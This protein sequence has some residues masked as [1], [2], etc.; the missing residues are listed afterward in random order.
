MPAQA[1]DRQARRVTS[2]SEE[3]ASLTRR[4]TV[5][6]LPALAVAAV[7]ALH[8]NVASTAHD[9]VPQ[10]EVDA[11]HARGRDLGPIPMRL[12]ND[13]ER[14]AAIQALALPPD[15]RQRLISDI[16]AGHVK[17]GW[18]SLYDSDTEDDDVVDIL[19]MGLRHTLML[20]KAPVAV[21]MPVPTDGRLRLFARSEG[22]GGG[23]TPGILTH[24]GPVA[25]PPMRVGET[26]T[27]VVMA[28]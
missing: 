10:A 14:E 1:T 19:S 13:S 11:R 23:V 7:A 17:L 25:L 8:F 24:Q 9:D 22:R 20:T 15:D 6:L 28:Q 3:T 21:A 16:A 12:V 18:V 2:A 4:V 5:L 27:L 26:L